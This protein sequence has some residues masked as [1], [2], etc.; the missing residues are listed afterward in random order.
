MTNIN[1]PVPFFTQRDNTYVW[2]YK[3]EEDT[4]IKKV[5]Y[6]KGSFVADAEGKEIS[7]KIWDYSCNITCLAMVLNYLGVTKDSPYQMCEKIFAEKYSKDDSDYESDFDR[8]ISYRVKAGVKAEVGNECIE[9]PEIISLIAKDIYK[10]RNVYVGYH[11]TLEDV[12]KEVKAGYPVIVSCG[13]IRPS[14]EYLKKNYGTDD[15]NRKNA[16]RN[17]SWEY[18]G[19]Y[20]VICGFIRD[21]YI[22][23]NDPW[24]K[25]TNDENRLPQELI[26]NMPNDGWGNYKNNINKGIYKGESIVITEEDF[27]RQYKNTFNSVV[28]VY[29][30]RWRFPF[31]SILNNFIK[32]RDGLNQ[33]FIP[34]PIE[35]ER[36]NMLE[37]NTSHFPLS[38]LSIPHNGIDYMVNRGTKIYSMGSGMVVAAK[39]CLGQNEE[40]SN[41]S[42]C[43]VL[44]KHSVQ[45]AE[46]RLIKTFFILYNH[47]SP[48]KIDEREIQ[49]SFVKELVYEKDRNISVLKNEADIKLQKLKKGEIVIFNDGDM[50][51][52]VAEYDLIGYTGAKGI[53]PYDEKNKIHIEIF[54]NENIFKDKNIFPE[55]CQVDISSIDIYDRSQVIEKY[56]ETLFGDFINDVNYKKFTKHITHNALGR[57]GIEE[58][59]KSEYKKKA[60]K[61]VVKSK[62]LWSADRNVAEERSLCK[63]FTFIKDDNYG[64]RYEKPYLWWTKEVDDA[65][66]NNLVPKIVNKIVFFIIQ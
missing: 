55:Y 22:L 14:L 32:I 35:V 61:I 45:I 17:Q 42:N 52:E 63:G 1:L 46:E 30:R 27:R 64:D 38:T 66:N 58:F 60:S 44:I 12:K 49:I 47:L 6:K 4:V 50:L 48:V 25:A 29:E 23:I 21:E 7:K 10:V 18:R 11:Y 36:C 56:K 19:H 2:Y 24:G 57:P 51:S 26:N 20:I 54:S 53:L 15:E 13:I 9:S 31:D 37:S 41:G 65:I 39:L 16:E 5:L 28:I 33:H 59:Y 8:Y 40:L 34:N 43:F 3:H 62:S